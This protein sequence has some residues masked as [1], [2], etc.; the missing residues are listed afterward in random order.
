MTTYTDGYFYMDGMPPIKGITNGQTWNG[1]EC[2]LFTRENAIKAIGGINEANGRE[3]GDYF[4]WEGDT[5]VNTYYYDGQVGD[6][7]RDNGIEI[8]GQKYYGVGYMSWVWDMVNIPELSAKFNELL[9]DELGE[10][11][12]E[13]VEGHISGNYANKD[14]CITHEY[15]DSNV[16][17][18]DAYETMV[19]E[20]PNIPSPEFMDIVNRAWEYSKKH[21]FSNF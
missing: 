6:V 7:Q 17:M 5:L 4:E 14:I 2:P 18:L 11:F 16:I 8:N 10:K 1:W 19:E 20:N 15:C 13:M 9:Q 3:N 12:G 21:N